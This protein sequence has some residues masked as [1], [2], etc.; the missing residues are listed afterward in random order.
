MITAAQ[1]NAGKNRHDP[2]YLVGFTLT[3][4]AKDW[5]AFVDTIP[6][7]TRINDVINAMIRD[8]K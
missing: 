2:E 4:K 8:R 1:K 6:R 7:G 5:D 3:V